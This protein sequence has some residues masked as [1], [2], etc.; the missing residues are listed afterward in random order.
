MPAFG[1]EL[2][3]EGQLQFAGSY[4]EGLAQCNTTGYGRCETSDQASR[5]PP[6]PT[7]SARAPAP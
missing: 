6:G 3:G 2:Q 4:Q 1:G 5:P 7:G